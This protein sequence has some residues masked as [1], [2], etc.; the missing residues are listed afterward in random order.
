[1]WASHQPS[2]RS[3]DLSGFQNDLM[4]V[5]S[6]SEAEN[7]LFTVHF[8]WGSPSSEQRVKLHPQGPPCFTSQEANDLVGPGKQLPSD[9]TEVLSLSLLPPPPEKQKRLRKGSVRFVS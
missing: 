3:D 4:L 2:S 7:G 9:P 6:V 8:L 5:Q 1:M